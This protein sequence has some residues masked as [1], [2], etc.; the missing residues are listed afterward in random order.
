MKKVLERLNTWHIVL[1]IIIALGTILA[2]AYSL[3]CHWD[4][5]EKIADVLLVATS[6]KKMILEQELQRICER[7]KMNWPCSTGP[8][9]AQD[10]GRYEQYQ[11]W[12]EAERLRLD[13]QMGGK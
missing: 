12:H 13:R 7:Y 1:V 6:N 11:K 8:M 9:N 2:G 4:E 10:K 5:D 3:D